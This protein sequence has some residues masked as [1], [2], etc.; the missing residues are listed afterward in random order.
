VLG[1]DA[2]SLAGLA[3]RF[4]ALLYLERTDEMVRGIDEA[5][6]MLPELGE[7]R[8]VA[9]YFTLAGEDGR[10][11]A[12]LEA[13]LRKDTGDRRARKALAQIHLRAGDERGARDAL[14][15]V[16]TGTPST[17]E[18]AKEEAESVSLLAMAH[19]LLGQKSEALQAL[20]GIRSPEAAA[21]DVA[22]AHALAGQTT[23]ALEWLEES[24]RS[25][26]I[27]RDWAARDPDL[28]SLRNEARFSEL[29]R[30]A[31]SP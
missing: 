23:Q 26:A 22:C 25:G 1:L 14:A 9:S 13:V 30:G 29:Q 18:S 5:T 15:P 3:G 19:A 27:D 17:F 6:A 20:Q 31:R 10:A 11:R 16:L 28:V 21:Y 4:R 7:A 12:I 24:L 8:W 2:R